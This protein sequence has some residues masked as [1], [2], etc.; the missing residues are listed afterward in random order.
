MKVDWV[1]H[2][3]LN[4]YPFQ[5]EKEKKIEND[6][7]KKNTTLL[8]LCHSSTF[9][10]KEIIVIYSLLFNFSVIIFP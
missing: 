5:I 3:I 7:E 8:L 4:F 9:D 10:I 2:Q 6:I 1:F